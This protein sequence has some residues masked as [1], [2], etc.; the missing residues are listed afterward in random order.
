MKRLLFGCLALLAAVQSLPAQVQEQESKIGFSVWKQTPPA[1]LDENNT[2]LLY[3]KIEQVIAR[4]SAGAVSASSV[5]FAIR[6]ELIIL[7]NDVVRNGVQDIHVY[8]AE[9]TLYAIGCADDNV[10]ASAVLSLNGNGRSQQEAIRQMISRLNI[11]DARL[12]RFIRTSQEKI[13]TF[14]I[15]N[16]PTIIAKADLLAQQGRY[17]EA[18]A[19][20]SFIPETVG[21]YD[22]ILERMSE[23]YQK[24]ID[25]YAEKELAR[26][27]VLM[28]KGEI[29][30][31]L[32]ILASI[33]PLSS[34]YGKA[35]RKVA[36][37]QAGIDAEMEAQAAARAQKLEMEMEAE[38]RR[39]D[40][41]IRVAEMQ[42]AA[43]MSTKG[44]L[45]ETLGGTIL[46]IFKDVTIG[47]I[48][49]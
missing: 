11:S 17:E 2:K 18:V 36:T 33:D 20:L 26:V 15:E 49:K 8:K 48:T 47:L 21:G 37:I 28:V 43:Q 12:T 35:K 42:K 38:Q 14:F 24:E 25:L 32:D 27:D 1:E 7:Q 16:A 10:F 9:L 22:S 19:M 23:Y 29:D 39:L 30:E 34:H 46:D 3:N 5:L 45:S 13:E 6:P 44:S 41:E 4:N 31:A 40:N